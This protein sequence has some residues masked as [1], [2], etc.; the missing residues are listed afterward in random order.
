MMA[1]ISRRKFTANLSIG[2]LGFLS[3]TWTALGATRRQPDLVVDAIRWS[4]DY[5][6]SWHTGPVPVGSEVW[7]EAKVR[8]VGSAGTPRRQAISVDFRVGGS[9]VAW[10]DAHKGGL[11]VSQSVILRAINGPDGSKY[12]IPMASGSYTAETSANRV[13]GE[14]NKSNNSLSAVLNVSPSNLV[15]NDDT[16][17]TLMDSSINIAVLANDSAPPGHEL[18]PRAGR[19]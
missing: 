14:K 6:G 11:A 19:S 17:S 16:A 12:W 15:A 9:V 18:V 1:K 7:F 8:N 4:D 3:P 13:S 2:T 5:G 10:S